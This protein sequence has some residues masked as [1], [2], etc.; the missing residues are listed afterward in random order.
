[1]PAGDIISVYTS[2]PSTGG[3][4]MY[5]QTVTG[6]NLPAVSSQFTSF[7]TGIAPFTGL[8]GDL[9]GPVSVSAPNGIPIYLAYS[10]GSAGT[11]YFDF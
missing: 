8:G 2:D 1:V 9:V 10:T 11:T 7:N 6:T 3:V 4:L 5:S